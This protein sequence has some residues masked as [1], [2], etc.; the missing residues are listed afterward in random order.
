M[1][2]NIHNCYKPA[3][4]GS[5]PAPLTGSPPAPPTGSPPPPLTGVPERIISY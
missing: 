1:Y 4:T 2:C 3:L 5:L